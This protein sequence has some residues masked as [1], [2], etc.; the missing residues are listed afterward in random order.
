MG[1]A[2]GPG[3]DLPQDGNKGSGLVPTSFQGRE[4]NSKKVSATC[5]LPTP[6]SLFGPWPPAP[7]SFSH[8]LHPILAKALFLHWPEVGNVG[9]ARHPQSPTHSSKNRPSSA[10]FSTLPTPSCS[11]VS[12]PFPASQ[13]PVRPP[14]RPTSVLKLVLVWAYSQQHSLIVSSSAFTDC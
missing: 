10:T 8:M 9:L 14:Q 5:F 7:K 11:V 1:W 3:G 12:R 2:S 6:P 4:R 13:P